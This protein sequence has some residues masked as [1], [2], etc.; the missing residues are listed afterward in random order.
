LRILNAVAEFHRLDDRE[1]AA[2]LGED[3]ATVRN[4]LDRLR[5]GAPEVEFVR[6]AEDCR[7]RGLLGERGVPLRATAREYRDS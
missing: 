2:T 7:A 3:A 1:I 5:S 4:A 6:F